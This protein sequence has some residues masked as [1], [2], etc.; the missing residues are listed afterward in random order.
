MTRRAVAFAPGS[1]GN[2]GPGFDVLGLAFAGAGVRAGVTLVDG[3]AP[4]VVVTG[5]DAEQIPTD[6]A[7]NA[8]AIAATSM[9]RRIGIAKRAAVRLHGELPVAGG[10]G[11]SGASSVA[12]AYAAA[13]ASG[14]PVPTDEIILA[15]LDGEGAVAGRH[16]DNIAPSVLGGLVLSRGIEP[17]DVVRLEVA[18]DWWLALVTPHVKVRTKDARDILPDETVRSEWIAEMGNAI[19]VAVAFSR[20]DG[21]LLRRSLHDVFAEPRRARLIP[22]FSEAKHAALDSGALGCSISGSGPTLFAVAQDEEEARR[23]AA[24]MQEAFGEIGSTAHVGPIDR[25]GVREVGE[26]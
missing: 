20:G 4:P 3:D 17:L 6:P 2:V 22:R 16:L 26:R 1:I 21:D 15:A 7:K 11:A 9:L 18:A 14:A 10:M 5:R 25:E 12:G 24:A 8:A 23:I 13:L 19:G